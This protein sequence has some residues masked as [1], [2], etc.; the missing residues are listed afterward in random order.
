MLITKEKVIKRL[1]NCAIQ[2]EV[3]FKFMMIER[4]A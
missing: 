1:T 4:V 2:N 3:E